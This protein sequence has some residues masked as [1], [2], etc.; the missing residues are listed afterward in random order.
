ME[1]SVI[2]NYLEKM[3]QMT[4]GQQ[5]HEFRWQFNNSKIITVS[6]MP[7]SVHLITPK[8]KQCF[9]N[10]YRISLFNEDVSYV[11]GI[12]LLGDIPIEH[13]WNK[14]GEIHFDVTREF[15]LKKFNRIEF[16]EYCS[17]IEV[18]RNRLIKLSEAN[19]TYG[20]HFS[21]Y[22]KLFADKKRD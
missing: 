14:I 10:A 15:A 2:K 7:D 9:T 13:A 1:N 22:Y 20:P 17:L 4:S 11:E 3:S 21:E 5:H 16:R 12:V 8:A 6:D 19:G 18:D